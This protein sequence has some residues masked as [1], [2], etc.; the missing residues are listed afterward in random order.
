MGYTKNCWWLCHRST[1]NC[2]GKKHSKSKSKSV[3]SSARKASVSS[4]CESALYSHQDPF[5]ALVIV[6]KSVRFVRCVRCTPLHVAATVAASASGSVWCTVSSPALVA[7]GT[8]SE[9]SDGR[10]FVSVSTRPC[11]SCSPVASSATWLSVRCSNGNFL[12]SSTRSSLS[13]HA[14]V[15]NK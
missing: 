15:M 13:N 14:L 2:E 11:T 8:S 10:L 3:A 9:A 1:T 6:R 12:P 5:S 7:G 4:G